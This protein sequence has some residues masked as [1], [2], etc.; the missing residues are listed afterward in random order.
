VAIPQIECVVEP[1]PKDGRWF[2]RILR[3][4]QYDYRLR[5]L[6]FIT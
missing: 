5:G 6:R 1:G 3:C 4:T 2:S